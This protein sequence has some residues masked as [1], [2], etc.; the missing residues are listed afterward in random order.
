MNRKLR[1]LIIGA[2]PDDADLSAG[3]TAAMLVRRGHT[4]KFL[5][6]TNG[7]AGHYA[8][9]PAALAARRRAEAAASGAILG[10]EYE[11]LNHEDGR[12]MPD[13]G[14][15]EDLMRAI[16]RFNPDVVITN[17]PNDYHADHRA[18]AQLVQDCAYLLQ[19]PHLC[20]D[21][22]AM[23]NPPAILF[24]WDEFQ[25]PQPFSPDIV[26][27]VDGCA[28][29]LIRMTKCHESQFYEWMLW[30]ENPA[31]LDL[32]RAEKEQRIAQRVCAGL[33][34]CRRQY[35]GRVRTLF[36]AQAQYIRHIE[37]FEK[38]EYGTPITHEIIAEM[39]RF[40]D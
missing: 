7:C 28:D 18:T 37:A 29:T 26:V 35:E 6:V 16:R 24:W 12:L 9:E 15:R 21:T 40:V 38:S 34:R 30:V 20:P 2:H 31:L 32:T 36:P 23:Q 11:V 39:E 13:I 17:R 3:G 4:V 8:M 1:F 27:P 10:C 5:S 22:P 19:V 25:K 33:E 14:T